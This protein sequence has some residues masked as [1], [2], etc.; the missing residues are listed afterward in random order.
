MAA[1]RIEDR[2]EEGDAN[3]G[4]SKSIASDHAEGALRIV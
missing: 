1:T 4:A 2:L 3:E